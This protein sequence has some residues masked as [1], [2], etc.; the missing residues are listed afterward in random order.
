MEGYSKGGRL[1]QTRETLAGSA[2]RAL[3]VA[4]PFHH[5]IFIE[6]DVDRCAV[7]EQLRSEKA[8]AAMR[9]A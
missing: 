9:I 3:A 5:F 4:P 7:L 6:K 1:R 2:R 8:G